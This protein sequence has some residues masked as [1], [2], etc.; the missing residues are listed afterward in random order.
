MSRVSRM[1]LKQIRQAKRASVPG[2]WRCHGSRSKLPAHRS[3]F[4]RRP[5]LCSAQDSHDLVVCRLAVVGRVTAHIAHDVNNSMTALLGRLQILLMR[6]TRGPVQVGT[7]IVALEHDAQTV[8]ERIQGLAAL[9]RQA[10]RVEDAA[11]CVLSDILRE[12]DHI[13]GH[14]LTRKGLEM[15]LDLPPSLP[16]AMARPIDIKLLVAGVA[17][18]FLEATARGGGLEVVAR[19]HK[20]YIQIDFEISGRTDDVVVMPEL[21]R[22]AALVAPVDLVVTLPLPEGDNARLLVPIGRHNQ[23]SSVRA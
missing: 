3:P 13:L 4:G 11:L 18:S 21:E 14:H 15:R 7:E 2:D 6:A 5:L 12:V 17:L 22:L 9:A 8:S 10:R 16:P 1:R 23:R 19:E 20:D